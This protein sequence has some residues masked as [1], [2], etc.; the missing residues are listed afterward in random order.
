MARALRAISFCSRTYSRR[1]SPVRPHDFVR[2]LNT[3]CNPIWVRKPIGKYLLMRLPISISHGGGQ[4]LVGLAKEID[5]NARI[6]DAT[7]LI[8]LPQKF[9]IEYRGPGL[10]RMPLLF[11]PMRQ[12]LHYAFRLDVLRAY[13]RTPVTRHAGPDDVLVLQD[14]VLQSQVGKIDP[15]A[16]IEI[17][18]L[19]VHRA[20]ICARPALPAAMHVLA[21]CEGADLAREIRIIVRQIPRQHHRVPVPGHIDAVQHQVVAR[22]EPVRVDE[23]LFVNS[24]VSLLS[25]LRS[26]QHLLHARVRAPRRVY[27]QKL[28]YHLERIPFATEIRVQEPHAAR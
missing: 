8:H 17:R 1:T 19:R 7:G 2:G 22:L 16:G 12:R 13:V 18:V 23:C 24:H 10:G 14:V 4:G 11:E 20:R 25:S 6:L 9:V 28:L 3:R 26:M 15:V 27:P 21:T 5:Q